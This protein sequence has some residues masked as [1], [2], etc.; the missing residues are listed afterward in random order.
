MQPLRGTPAFCTIL[1]SRAYQTQSLLATCYLVLAGISQHY[2][3]TTNRE[4]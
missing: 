3:S 2:L 4:S 1:R